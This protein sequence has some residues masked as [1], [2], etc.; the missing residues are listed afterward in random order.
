MT[1]EEFN[2]HAAI[3]LEQLYDILSNS[4]A[5]NGNEMRERIREMQVAFPYY[6]TEKDK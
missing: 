4:K 6:L 5:H 3:L 1:Q 2:A